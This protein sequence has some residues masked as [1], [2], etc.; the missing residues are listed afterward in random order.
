MS[1]FSFFKKILLKCRHLQKQQVE[2]PHSLSTQEDA[3]KLL[4]AASRARPSAFSSVM[5]KLTTV[6]VHW[7]SGC[8]PVSIYLEIGMTKHRVAYFFQVNMRGIAME[9]TFL[10]T[11]ICLLIC[12]YMEI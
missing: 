6:I 3:F 5:W 12:E 9:N 2:A 11:K 4:L 7:N 8:G 1:Q 10:L